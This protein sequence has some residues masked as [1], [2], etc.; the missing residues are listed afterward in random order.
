M[1]R[2]VLP[3][4]SVVLIAG[5][6]ASPQQAASAP[7]AAAP[8]DPQACDLLTAMDVKLAIG[9][10]VAGGELTGFECMFRRPP[11][12]KDLR[13]TAA[14]V[15]LEISTGKPQELVDRYSARMREALGAYDLSSEPVE[16]GRVVAWDGDAMVAAAPMT[17]TRSAFVIV[18]LSGIDESQQRRIARQL[19]DQA[20]NKLK[21]R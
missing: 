20:L 8:A 6:S 9:E 1:T 11:N 7:V 18:Q 3:I 13:T 4:L 15:R 5:C 21:T 2:R 12:E 16:P 17:P 19:V 14:Q 10:D